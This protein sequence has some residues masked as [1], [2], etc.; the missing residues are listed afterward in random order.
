M[1]KY[2]DFKSDEQLYGKYEVNLKYIMS[3]RNISRTKLSK[4]TGI[5]YDII[6]KYYKGLCK[7]IDLGTI[8]KICYFLACDIQD[9][10]IFKHENENRGIDNEE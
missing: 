4:L 5:K 7:Q 9:I 1:N 10:L 3:I 2:I 8:T 6:N